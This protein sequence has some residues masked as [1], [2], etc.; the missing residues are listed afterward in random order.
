MRMR[1]ITMLVAALI[2]APFLGGPAYAQQPSQAEQRADSMMNIAHEALNRSDY[3]RAAATF[4]SLQQTYPEAGAARTALYWQAFAQYRMG[5][6]SDLRDARAAL[7]L[8][9]QRYPDHWS[10]D[11]R[12]LLM[13]VEGMLAQLGDISAAEAVTVAASTPSPRAAPAPPAAVAAPAAPSPRG[14]PDPP[15]AGNARAG[16]S[17]VPRSATRGRPASC[18][19][20]DDY[21]VRLEALNAL[22]QVDADRALPILRQVLQRRDECSVEMRRRAV[23]LIQQ[24]RVAD[25]DRIL[26]D[27]A[28]N[29][30]D[31]DVRGQ[32]VHW[33]ASVNTEGAIAALEEI[34]R[35]DTD[36][37]LRQRAVFALSNHRS[38]RAPVILR[39]LVED[40]RAP[41]EL[42]Q[43]AIFF[44]AQRRGADTEFLRGLYGRVQDE[45]LKE[46]LLY[47][48]SQSPSDADARWLMDIALR[49]NEPIDLRKR[50]LFW[51][52]QR[53]TP[54]PA[55][56]VALY[57]RVTDREMKEQL[58][59][60][61]TQ[62][63]TEEGTTKLIEIARTERDPE[64]RKRAIFWLG[65]S[66]DPRAA[67]VLQE[68]ITP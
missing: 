61:Y 13:R 59:Y 22:M 57:D 38:E 68:L 21:E 60:L 34:V 12:S 67:Q 15:A 5:A 24:K 6:S 56:L 54:P 20:D 27:V 11:A 41:V 1:L 36:M 37:Q 31:P 26:L 25:S 3:R 2:A 4:R 10:A 48:L 30:P 66:R 55:E 64:L 62:R 23:F 28:R 32:A 49:S 35:S 16:A 39:A 46:H 44:M 47:A 19:R 17:N 63:R 65:Q 50:A 8:M 40:E 7:T 14:A 42:R 43:Q 33:L 53:S 52:A 9:Q 58:I 51:A 18:P 45:R 29:D